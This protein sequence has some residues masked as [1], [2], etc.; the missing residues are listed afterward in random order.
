MWKPTTM[1]ASASAAQ[2]RSHPSS[3]QSGRPSGGRVGRNAAA[4]PASRLRT[5]SST[6]SSMSRSGI[7]AQHTKR[8]EL[9]WNV[10]AN[11]FS[12]RQAALATSGVR[13]LKLQIPSD[14]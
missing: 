13:T 8:G 14:G 10:S 11:S 4:K 12:A 9:A 3:F 6:A 5:T 7:E 1:P 2:R